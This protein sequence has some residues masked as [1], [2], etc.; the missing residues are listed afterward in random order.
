MNVH[1]MSDRVLTFER[2]F[3]APRDVVFSLWTHPRH[4]VRWYGPRGH[5]LTVC[6]QDFREGGSWRICM[7][8]G[9][10]EVWIWGTYR[11]IVVPEK[12]VFSSSMHF[13]RYE[14]LVTIHFDDLGDGTTLMRFRQG[15]FG[16]PQDCADHSW[17]WN[18]ALDCLMDYMLRLRDAGNLRAD[19]FDAN[20]RDGLSED[21]AE[22]AARAK[23]ERERGD[24]FVPPS[25]N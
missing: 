4:L 11:Q 22:A 24:V 3:N 5:S 14:T 13:H 8:R 15:E 25:V 10:E 9:G 20:R 17:G 6:E 16:N 19:V 21:F 2:K 23:A 7:D 1:N 18:S 12:L